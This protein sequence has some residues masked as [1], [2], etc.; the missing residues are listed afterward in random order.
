[1]H[2]KHGHAMRHS[3]LNAIQEPLCRV[4]LIHHPL[5]HSMKH[6]RHIYVIGITCVIYIF[7]FL[8]HFTLKT[9]LTLSC[10]EKQIKN[11]LLL[12]RAIAVTIS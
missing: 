8:L 12:I 7:M 4:Y 3:Q 5:I 6:K 9:Q 1:M 11:G 2:S 10:Q